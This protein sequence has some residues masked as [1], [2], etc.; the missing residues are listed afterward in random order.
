MV[1]NL[2]WGAGYFGSLAS[3]LVVYA[4]LVAPD[5]PFFGLDRDM[6]EHLRMAAPVAA[7]W[8]LVFAAPLVLF[9]PAEAPSREPAR[10]V[11]AEGLRDLWATL[12]ALPFVVSDRPVPV[13]GDPG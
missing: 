5:P 11:V 8:F 2:G 13:A 6:A 7:L 9:G 10:R 3:L 4:L 1:Q 12:M